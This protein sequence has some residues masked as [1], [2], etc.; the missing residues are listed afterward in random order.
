MT[1]TGLYIYIPLLAAA[2][3]GACG[4]HFVAGHPLPGGAHAIDVPLFR[5][6]SSETGAEA[7]FAG[8]L[9]DELALQGLLAQSSADA[10]IEGEITDIHSGPGVVFTLDG[11]L[12]LPGTF[13]VEAAARVRLMRGGQVLA[14]ADVRGVEDYARGVGGDILGSEAGRRA[15]IRRL[16]TSMMRDALHRL[17]TDF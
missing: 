13:R 16:A 7:L 5:N 1:G 9:R 2:L 6:A 14:Q 12:P 3:L 10:T 17:R 8:T 4:Y 11:G 15:A